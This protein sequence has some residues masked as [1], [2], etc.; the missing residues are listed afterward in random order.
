VYTGYPTNRRLSYRRDR[1]RYTEDAMI[2]LPIEHS[3]TDYGPS[4]TLDAIEFCRTLTRREP[5]T[6][7][8]APPGS[9]M[10]VAAVDE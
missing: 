5:G 3:I 7:Q 2:V 10:F 9:R 4:M 1:T 6:G 8:I